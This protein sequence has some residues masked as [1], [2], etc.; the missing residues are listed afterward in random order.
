MQRSFGR[1]QRLLTPTNVSQLNRNV[2]ED[3]FPLT[4]AMVWSAFDDHHLSV[5]Q[6]NYTG[7]EADLLK[8]SAIQ[9]LLAT[10]ARER[11]NIS[12]ED[13]FKGYLESQASSEQ[14]EVASFI[15]Q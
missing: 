15:P 8:V 6:E 14:S 5:L 13:N 12:F 7:N 3:Q 1:T 10:S 11:M 2:E 9:F 4:Q